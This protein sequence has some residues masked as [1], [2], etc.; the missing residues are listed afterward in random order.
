MRQSFSTIA[1]MSRQ[2]RRND[3]LGVLKKL[4]NY[5]CRIALKKDKN[6]FSSYTSF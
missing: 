5:L 4:I 6:L 1:L 2:R 3:A